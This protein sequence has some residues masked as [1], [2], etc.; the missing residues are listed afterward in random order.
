[1]FMWSCGLLPH[2]TLLKVH[3]QLGNEGRTT[4]LYLD[5]RSFVTIGTGTMLPTAESAKQVGFTHED[6]DRP[7]TDQEKMTPGRHYS[8]SV[9]RRRTRSSAPRIFSR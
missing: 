5:T 3:D 1:M 6:T 7:A 2:D 4:K 8:A 9:R